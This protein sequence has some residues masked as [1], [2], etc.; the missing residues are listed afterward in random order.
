MSQGVMGDGVFDK[1]VDYWDV[2]NVQK[3]IVNLA[4]ETGNWKIVFL[5]SG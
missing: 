5:N 1:W 3:E 4:R 2:I